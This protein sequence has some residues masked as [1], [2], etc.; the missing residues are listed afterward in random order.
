[1]QREKRIK[2]GRLFEAEFYPVFADGRRVPTRAPKT[3]RSTEE[4]ARYNMQ[5]AIK[6]FLRIVNTNFDS[7]DNLAHFTYEPGEA[8]YS[9][10]QGKADMAVFMR[11]VKARR[12]AELREIER[13]IALDGTN[14]KLLRKLAKLKAPFKYAYRIEVETFKRGAR[15]GQERYHFH[16]FMTGGLDRDD[17]EELWAR[18]GCNVDRFRPERFGPEAAALYFAKTTQGRLKFCYSKNLDRPTELAPRDGHIGAK[19]VEKLARQRTDDAAFWERRYKG[20]KFLHC[21]SRYN[22]HNGFWYVSVVMYK[23]ESEGPLP[24]WTRDIKDEDWIF[25]SV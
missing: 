17:I 19:G 21:Y 4:Q 18:G 22:P 14:R 20:Y 1:M 16:L 11:K 9:E 3:K 2:S 6:N 25:E 12:K 7:Y 8:P 13:L 24:E 15:K 5:K 23:P 10:E